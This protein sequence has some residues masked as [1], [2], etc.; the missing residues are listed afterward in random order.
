MV[1]KVPHA[2]ESE[3]SF[4]QIA[5]LACRVSDS[6]GLGWGLE[7]AFLTVFQVMVLLAQRPNIENHS[8]G[9]HGEPSQV[10]LSGPSFASQLWIWASE[11]SY[12]RLIK[13][14]G[15]D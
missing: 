7:L 15:L 3:S 6:V 8:S 13:P 2:A 12:T 14:L 5:E 11:G 4:R 10:P 9:A 1:L